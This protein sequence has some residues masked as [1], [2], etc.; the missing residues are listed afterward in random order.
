MN[1]EK[2]YLSVGEVSKRSGIAVSAL[3]FYETKGLL[4]TVRNAGNQRR[5]HRREL[6]LLSY[7]KV[8]QK[9]GLTLEEIKEAFSSIENKEHLT[10][11]EWKKL[12]QSW[13]RVLT[14]RLELIQ[15]MKSQLSLCIGCGCL[16]LKIVL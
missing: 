13:D 15:R 2:E 1:S 3:H 5:I 16:S 6:R 12:G 4:R 10:A 9:I 14:E 11:K 8:A 7:I